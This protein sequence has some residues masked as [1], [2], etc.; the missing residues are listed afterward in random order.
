[1]KPR[2]QESSDDPSTEV[3][4]EDCGA[5]ILVFRDDPPQLGDNR[6]DTCREHF[7]GWCGDECPMLKH[8]PALL[9]RWRVGLLRECPGHHGAPPLEW[10]ALG[11]VNLAIRAWER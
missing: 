6:C 9:Y 5:D 10:L 1:M 2:G 7:L 8:A 4:C 3:P 11:A